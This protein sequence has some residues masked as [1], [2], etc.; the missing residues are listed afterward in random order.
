MVVPL[1]ARGR[2][3]GALTFVAAESDRRYV[4]SDLRLAEEI[5][6]RAALA[7]DNARLYERA[8]AATRSRDDLLAIVSHDLRNLLGVM[9]MSV[10]TMRRAPI[11]E[12]HAQ[13]LTRLEHIKRSGDRMRRLL[14]DLLDTAS[15]EAGICRWN[16]GR[17]R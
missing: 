14:E 15:I 16:W 12:D 5:G 9:L 6:R 3:L 17:S 10:E 2:T 7:I 1:L 8:Q 13:S 11:D 4:S